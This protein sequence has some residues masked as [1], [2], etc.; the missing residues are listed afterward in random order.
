MT[1]RQ[2][3]QV[4]IALAVALFLWGLV[5]IFGGGSDTIEEREL[6]PALSAE[7]VDA[8]EFAG[9]EETVRLT[10]TADGEWSVNAYAA[11]PEAVDEL[12]QAVA[13]PVRGS[14]VAR[15]ASSHVRMGVDSVGGRRLRV[16]R[17]GHTLADLVIGN[18]GRQHRTVYVRQAGDD[19]VYQIRGPL[20]TLA[21]RTVTDW[22]D[23][24]IIVLDLPQIRRVT[25]ERGRDRY[26]LVRADSVW[27]FAD[28][29]VADSAA[30]AG[31]LGEFRTISAQGSAFATP[32]QADSAD[33]E[34]PDRSLT[35]LKAGGDTLAALVFDSTETGYWVRHAAGGTVYRLYGW[36]ADDLTPRDST[37]RPAGTRP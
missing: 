36:K 8:V 35:L 23:K 21:G 1:P 6:S 32:A 33:F 7:G 24:R 4:G 19:N 20:S 22:R 2:L 16:T 28:G 29:G 3:L 31:L 9:G 14:L 30:V 11:S 27:S 34:R 10:R 15:G 12:F 25:V 13:G 5:A 37:L 26:T 18:Q 17:G